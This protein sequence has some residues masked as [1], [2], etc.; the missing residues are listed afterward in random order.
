M[1]I[2]RQRVRTDGFTPTPTLP[3]ELRLIDFESAM[4]DVYDFFFDVN[5]F[6]IGNGLPRLEETLRAAN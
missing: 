2:Q 5:S 4:Q 3:Y 6:L 1:P